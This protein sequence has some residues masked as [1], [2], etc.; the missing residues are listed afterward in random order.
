MSLAQITQVKAL[1]LAVPGDDIVARNG[2]REG[3]DLSDLGE[4]HD[5]KKN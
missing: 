1:A 2:E 3:F 5:V 4:G